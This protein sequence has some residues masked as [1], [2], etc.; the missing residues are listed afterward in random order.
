MA[1]ITFWTRLEP[2]SRLDDI[3]TG[4]QAQTHDPL[5][6]LARQWQ[7][8]EFQGED[9]GTPVL[10]KFRRGALAARALPP[11]PGR[12]GRAV[13]AGRPAR[14]ARRAR[15]GAARSPTPAATCASPPT[16]GLYFLR[17]LERF[18][19]SV[20]GRQV[21]AAAPSSSCPRRPA[22]RTTTPAAATSR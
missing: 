20:A 19:V 22:R 5:W 9:A 8:G 12:A 10:A 7:T 4:L 21:F 17:L 15:A 18:K 1:S 11:G 16:P 6:L 13:P 14:D 3:D 2:F